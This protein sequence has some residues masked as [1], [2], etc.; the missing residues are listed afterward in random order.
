MSHKARFIAAA[1]VAALAV[2][3]LAPRLVTP[4]RSLFSSKE[5]APA[6]ESSEK[7][8]EGLVKLTDE[9]IAAAQVMWLANVSRKLIAARFGCERTT[10]WRYVMQRESSILQRDECSPA[11]ETVLK[12]TGSSST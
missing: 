3:F 11:D 1:V 6:A 2:V 12:A 5:S 9:Q 7:P 10:I 4:L 8:V